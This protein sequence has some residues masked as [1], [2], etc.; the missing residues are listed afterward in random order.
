MGDAPAFLSAFVLGH[1]LCKRRFSRWKRC[2]T[3]NVSSLLLKT[4][5]RLS[6]LHHWRKCVWWSLDR[7]LGCVKSCYST[8]LRVKLSSVVWLTFL[9][10]SV[11]KIGSSQGIY[12]ALSSQVSVASPLSLSILSKVVTP[13]TRRNQQPVGNRGKKIFAVYWSSVTTYW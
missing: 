1:H 8:G 9:V 3:S 5:S 10:F 2:G 4:C 13:P 7:N 12:T 6:W 11:V